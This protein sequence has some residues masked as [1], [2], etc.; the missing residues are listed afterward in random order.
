MSNKSRRGN[1]NGT[2]DASMAAEL[3][4]MQER[5]QSAVAVE[6]PEAS[7]DPEAFKVCEAGFG[8]GQVKMEMFHSGGIPVACNTFYEDGTT[9]NR[10]KTV[11]VQVAVEVSND[12]LDKALDGI[13]VAAGGKGEVVIH[14]GHF[15]TMIVT[16][17][18]MPQMGEFILIG[19]RGIRNMSR[20]S[21]G[22]RFKPLTPAIH[23]KGVDEQRGE[24]AYTTLLRDGFLS[25]FVKVTIIHKMEDLRNIAINLERWK[26]GIGYQREEEVGSNGEKTG[27]QV[28]VGPNYFESP[29]GEA[30]IFSGKGIKDKAAV[31]LLGKNPDELADDDPKKKELE[32]KRPGLIGRIGQ[33]LGAS[34]EAAKDAGATVPRNR[35]QSRN[36][37]TSLGD[38]S[39]LA[40]ARVA[41]RRA[42]ELA[43]RK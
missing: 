29:D 14:R 33:I 34:F 38:D 35:E 24:F 30:V 19:V 32:R 37:G 6:E 3:A 42:A 16:P 39:M 5:E 9:V 22:K 21:L 10:E 17:L 15:T 43:T 25:E 31:Y 28:F 27:R 7:A 23:K 36:F 12:L 8:E 40:A 2:S 18:D 13:K 4:A 11:I 20:G 26:I 1:G 41:A